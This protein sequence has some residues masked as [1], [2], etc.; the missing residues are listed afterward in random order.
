VCSRGELERWLLA[1]SSARP[2]DHRLLRGWRAEFAEGLQL[3]PPS[4]F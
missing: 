2:E 1:G 4:L 3:E